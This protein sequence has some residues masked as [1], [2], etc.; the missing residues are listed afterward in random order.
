MFVERFEILMNAKKYLVNPIL[1]IKKKKKIHE[2]YHMRLCVV[3]IN[4]LKNTRIRVEK[5]VCQYKLQI[6]LY[7]RVLGGLISLS[8]KKIK[9]SSLND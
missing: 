2:L 4:D 8:E 7:R 6:H 5:I 1:F 3:T 9:G